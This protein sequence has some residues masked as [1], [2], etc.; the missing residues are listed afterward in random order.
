MAAVMVVTTMMIIMETFLMDW[1]GEGG[2]G[3]GGCQRHKSRPFGLVDGA[4]AELL[5]VDDCPW[6]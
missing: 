1:F 5:A 4:S 3:S 6:S 2:G